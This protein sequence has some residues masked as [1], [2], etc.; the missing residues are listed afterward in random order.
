MLVK[1][2]FTT[3]EEVMQSKVLPYSVG[4]CW[5]KGSATVVKWPL[6]FKSFSHQRTHLGTVSNQYQWF[7]ESACTCTPWAV[8]FGRHHWKI[9]SA[10][11]RSTAGVTLRDIW[12]A[13]YLKC[14]CQYNP[15]FYFL[16]DGVCNCG[17][18]HFLFVAKMTPQWLLVSY[19]VC[20]DLV[21]KLQ[22]QI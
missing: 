18:A 11:G 3:S 1:R 15:F 2:G 7:P 10:D 21:K 19:F 4:T 5:R 6:F 16:L 20:I 22:H 13:T 14:T 9:I 17:A 8:T 12:F